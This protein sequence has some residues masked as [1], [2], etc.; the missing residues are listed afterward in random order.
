MDHTC[1][2]VWCTVSEGSYCEFWLARSPWHNL[3]LC[4]VQ[5]F[6]VMTGL[7]WWVEED[8]DLLFGHTLR[9]FH[10]IYLEHTVC[11]SQPFHLSWETHLVAMCVQWSQYSEHHFDGEEEE[12]KSWA[13]NRRS[14]LQIYE[15]ISANA[16][17]KSW[18][19]APP[20]KCWSIG[21]IFITLVQ[22]HTGQLIGNSWMFF[23]QALS[24]L[25]DKLVNCMCGTGLSVWM[26]M[27]W[28]E[29]VLI[30][31]FYSHLVP[32]QEAMKCF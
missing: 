29:V 18:L 12:E 13:V 6:A 22:Y 28:V 7:H 30:Y 17:Q 20:G 24:P 5:H 32:Q 21:H 14:L 27:P 9:R 1:R 8:S 16:A 3:P 25:T 11:H 19:S 10:I 2:G 4:Y 26:N 31:V 15:P 23:F